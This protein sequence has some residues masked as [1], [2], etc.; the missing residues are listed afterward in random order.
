[1]GVFCSPGFTI[2]DIPFYWNEKRYSGMT[3][4]TRL[5]TQSPA[6]TIDDL[7][8]GV[9]RLRGDELTSFGNAI[10]A[11]Y[12]VT[13]HPSELLIEV[14]LRTCFWEELPCIILLPGSPGMRKVVISAHSPSCF[15]RTVE[16]LV[17]CGVLIEHLQRSCSVV[18]AIVTE[19]SFHH[20]IQRV[21]QAS[22][23]RRRPAITGEGGSE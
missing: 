12:L 23:I 11:G 21:I 7:I 10:C 2:F 9:Y 5:F 16:S 14:Y 17:E 1:M 6:T 20:V 19:A 4:E 18:T 13:S 3:D 22:G 15:A 8:A